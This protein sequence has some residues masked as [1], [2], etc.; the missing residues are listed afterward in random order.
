MAV[1]ECKAVWVMCMLLHVLYA[2]AAAGR[3]FG[4]F[5]ELWCV[6][7]GLFGRGRG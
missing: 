1:G 3:M 7:V 2:C 4:S 5:M 6:G